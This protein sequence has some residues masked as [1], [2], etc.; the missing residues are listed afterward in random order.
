MAYYLPRLA[1]L[2]GISAPKALWLGVMNPLVL[3]LFVSARTTTP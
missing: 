1:F 3:L 2:C